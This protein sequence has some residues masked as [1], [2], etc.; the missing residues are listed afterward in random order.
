M[1]RRTRP[2]VDRIDFSV[3]GTAN[4]AGFPVKCADPLDSFDQIIILLVELIAREIS[5]VTYRRP[6]HRRRIPARSF[7]QAIRV[8]QRPRSHDAL[9]DLLNGLAF[10]IADADSVPHHSGFVRFQSCQGFAE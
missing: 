10:N 7:H 9:R 6:H 2:R 5:R 3:S 4:G 8:L 1:R